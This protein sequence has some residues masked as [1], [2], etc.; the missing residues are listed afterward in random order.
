VSAPEPAGPVAVGWL[1]RATVAV[2]RRPS[3]WWTALRQVRVLARPGWWRSSPRLPVPDPAYLRFR[4]QTMYG[5][6]G[7]DPDP[8]DLVT[9]L[10]WC[11]A[12]PEVSAR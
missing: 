1:G 3:L 11:K 10:H 7:H 2:L 12:W 4:M 6:P 5:D 8:D 9:Y